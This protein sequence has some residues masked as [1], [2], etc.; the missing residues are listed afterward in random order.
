MGSTAVGHGGW[1]VVADVGIHTDIE[2][3][4]AERVIDSA[5]V[6]EGEVKA[7]IYGVS[8]PALVEAR[9]PAAADVLLT[10]DVEDATSAEVVGAACAGI[11]SNPEVQGVVCA[12]RLCERSRPEEADSGIVG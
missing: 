1:A 6:D 5:A 10:R 2:T 4:G 7:G 12:S 9:C 11:V 8:A 3:A